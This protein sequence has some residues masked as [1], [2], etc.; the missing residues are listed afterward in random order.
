[1]EKGILLPAFY[2]P[3]TSFFTQIKQNTAAIWLEKY[4]HFPK[5]TYR[6]R[7]V[8]YTANGPLN[9]S[10]PIRKGM[11]E[12]TKMKDV[13]IS[14]DADW[15]RLHWMSLQTAYRTS[16]YFEYY[17]ETFAPFYQKKETFLFDFNQKLLIQ[18]LE[19]LKMPTNFMYTE[20][21]DPIPEGL[22]DFR[23]SI[24]PKKPTL[25][26]SKPYCQVFED[27]FGFIPNLSIIDL[28]CT[29]GPHAG[30]YF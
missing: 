7:C 27:K 3:P 12:H 28:L 11:R 29:Q 17:E 5:Q 22:K 21:Y 10:I 2:M 23:T 15:Q 24:H 16:P 20:S 13:Q 30:A 18:I 4:E 9:L 6:N 14:Y 26:P 19:L 1:M 8:I 25:L